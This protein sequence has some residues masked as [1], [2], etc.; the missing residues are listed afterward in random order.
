MRLFNS[1]HLLLKNKQTN[2][3]VSEQHATRANHRDHAN[4]A[5]GLFFS[6]FL[7]KDHLRGHNWMHFAFRHSVLLP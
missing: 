4:W 3:H 1:L 5:D 2:K 6:E 7:L